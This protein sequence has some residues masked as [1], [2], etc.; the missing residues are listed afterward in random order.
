MSAA[1]QS[2]AAA[3]CA[4]GAPITSQTQLP[5]FEGDKDAYKVATMEE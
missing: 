3:R 5:L 4:D 2:E 1:L